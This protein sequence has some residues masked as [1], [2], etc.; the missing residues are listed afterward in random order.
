[1]QQTKKYLRFAVALTCLTSAFLLSVSI[2]D[3]GLLV[4]LRQSSGAANGPEDGERYELSALRIFNRVLLNVSDS[5]VE[6]ERVKPDRMLISALEEIQN[7]VAPVVI[8]Y[9]R[10]GDEVPEEVTVQVDGKK[11]VFKVA[12]VES[13]WEMSLK[14]KEIFGF[15]QATLGD[16]PDVDYQK[17]EY[18]AIN[19][20]LE[21]LDPHSTLL[22][23]VN[24]EDMQ[25]Q[26]GGKFGGLGIVIS[27]RDNALTVM[28]PIDDTPA[29]RAGIKARD[30]IVRIAEEST[31]NMSL[32]EA[33]NM[34]RGDPGTKVNL[35][36]MRQGWD[37][38]R[39]FTV[40]RAIIKIESVESQPLADKIGYIRIKNF[41]ANTTPDTRTHLKE[42]KEKMGGMQGLILDLRD[43]P[44]GLLNQS[45][46]ISDLFIDEG[47]IVSTVG[48][49]NKMRDK[50]SARSNNTE[51]KYPIV[52]LVN[53]GSASASEIVSGAIQN[54]DRG[55][56][57][58][59]TTFGKG[60]VQVLYELPDKSA[61]KLTIAQYL[62]P[63]DISIQGKGITPDLRAVPV[64][65]DDKGVDLFE[66]A[67]VFREGDLATAL[68]SDAVRKGTKAVPTLRFLKA[69]PKENDDGFDDGAFQEDY[70]ITLAQ[71]LLVAAGTT[72]ERGPM[73]KKIA[74]ELGKV[75]DR[76]QSEITAAL[77]KRGIDWSSGPSPADP[78][79]T[80]EV[81]PSVDKG[82]VKAGEKMTL[83]A[84]LTNDGPAPLHRI[85]AIT[86]SDNGVLDDREFIFGKLA[87]GET[88]EFS[89]DVKI[90][91][92]TPDRLDFVRFEISDAANPISTDQGVD[93]RVLG[94]PRPHFAFSYELDDPSGDGLLSVG[95]EVKLK[96]H[97]HNVGK[98]DSAETLVYIKNK[99]RDAIYLE[100]GR[101]KLE[102]VAAA[103]SEVVD[104]TFKAQKAPED[105][106]YTF[107]VDVYDVTYREFTQKTFS[108]PFA[109]TP[110]EGAKAS[111]TLTLEKASEARAGADTKSE[112]VAA[113]AK[114]AVARV[115]GKAGDF[116][117]VELGGRTGWVDGAIA[118]FKDG[119]KADPSGVDGLKL[120]RS[121][122]V[123]LST[124][125]MLTDKPTV[126]LTGVFGD[127]SAIKDYYV[128]VY[129]RE[130]STFNT[131]KVVY[132][133]VGKPSKE[134]KVQIPLFAGMNRITAFVRDDSGMTT[135]KSVYVFRK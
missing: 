130:D 112:P 95:E 92:D 101:S 43:N 37:E 26:T 13:L 24:Y 42:L 59:D 19:G 9:P 118:T 126:G 51:P 50:K 62:T 125:A 11:K 44:G 68:T 12:G 123:A 34:L 55:V 48:Q 67:N 71:R 135:T 113:L 49:G 30:K 131:R 105:G 84:K 79:V 97:V 66:S 33:V 111:G 87:P 74:G 88:R 5:Y 127:D 72:W 90:P 99:S 96:V 38:P 120:F 25:T 128:F 21:T 124:S 107:E 69:A 86:K 122:D 16:D 73:L 45:I 8:S 114:G 41:Q 2:G 89:V 18:A 75:S 77:A 22:P 46:S 81:V 109:K 129:N 40:E 3:R 134:A 58:G 100:K 31:V 121:P 20:M 36:I 53:P 17:V 103:G 110:L 91:Q 116:Y 94:Q 32:T 108:I 83:T 23:P 29:A 106:A 6:P 132:E 56:V 115:V 47:T 60:S 28:S 119:A 39:K 10:K 52:V 4:D 80:L 78:K 61:L 7:T 102:K 85:K 1:M 82:E 35:W 63:G 117:E 27:I 64:R 98:A 133:R 14:V 76:E 70:E 54:N 65:V 15:I 93:V 104:F 57:L